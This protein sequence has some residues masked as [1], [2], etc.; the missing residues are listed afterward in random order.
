M[1]S[2]SPPQL[3]MAWLQWRRPWVRE[4]LSTQSSRMAWSMRGAAPADGA[5]YR[6]FAVWRASRAGRHVRHKSAV[7]VCLVSCL[8]ALILFPFLAVFAGPVQIFEDQC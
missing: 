4:M 5:S 8:L 6:T 1:G 3:G 7:L 2:Q